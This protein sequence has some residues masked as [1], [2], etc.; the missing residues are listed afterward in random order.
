MT[1][2]VTG[3]HADS[4]HISFDTLNSGKWIATNIDL[5]LFMISRSEHAKNMRR[6]DAKEDSH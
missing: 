3:Q 4:T 6:E 5:I 2:N 1:S